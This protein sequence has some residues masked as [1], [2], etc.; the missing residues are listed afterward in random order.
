MLLLAGAAPLRQAEDVEIE[1]GLA[2]QILIV[3]VYELEGL[4]DL[5][6]ER[7]LGGQEHQQLGRI[8]LEEHARDLLGVARPERV[9][10]RVEPVAELLLVHRQVVVVAAGGV[11]SE[12]R[13]VG[14]RG[15]AAAAARRGGRR[16]GL[17]ARRR[18]ERARLEGQGSAGLAVLARRA[19]VL[20]INRLFV[21]GSRGFV[22]FDI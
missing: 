12:G 16:G 20:S 7:L 8:H 9:D 13:R 11:A 1:E 15:G 14:R 21:H 6:P 18:V 22:E 5:L 4:L 17:E 2:R 3:A 19:W 10:L